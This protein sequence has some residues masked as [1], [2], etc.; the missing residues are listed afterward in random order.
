[1][2]KRERE[3]E[4]P[5]ASAAAAAAALNLLIA[6]LMQTNEQTNELF[7]VQWRPLIEDSVPKLVEDAVVVVFEPKLC[8]CASSKA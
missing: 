1:M 2:L 6:S 7:Q 5:A 8:G 3:R 4:R